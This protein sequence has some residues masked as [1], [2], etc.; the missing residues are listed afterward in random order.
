MGQ[1]LLFLRLRFSRPELFDQ[2]DV[3]D[4]RQG[5]GLAFDRSY[6][7]HD[8]E[9]EYRQGEQPAEGAREVGDDPGDHVRDDE[10]Q[11]L[12]QMEVQILSAS[13]V[14]GAGEQSYEE[15]DDVM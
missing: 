14:V 4:E 2:F 8:P 13:A 10:D 6:E 9:Y 11:G 7:R 1:S 15:T 12:I 5:L 3:L